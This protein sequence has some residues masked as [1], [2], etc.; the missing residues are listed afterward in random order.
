M[1]NE[2]LLNELRLGNLVRHKCSEW[3][4]RNDDGVIS[5]YGNELFE[6]CFQWEDSDWYALLECTLPNDA[7]EPILLT[8]KILEHFG[9]IKG[10]HRNICG[11]RE[12]FYK[13]DVLALRICVINDITKY[14]FDWFDPLGREKY[15]EVKHL[16]QLQNI[17]YTFV[18]EEMDL[19]IN[20]L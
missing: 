5:N 4:Y 20:K 7:F 16:H 11:A 17:Y 3:S 6:D 2:N 14:M 18:G 13:G 19:K 8:P 12:D 10:E 1:E 15:V 9:F